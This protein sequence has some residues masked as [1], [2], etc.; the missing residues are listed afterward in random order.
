MHDPRRAERHWLVMA[1]A[2]LWVVSVGG[3]VDAQ[4]PAST[5]DALPETHIA[6]TANQGRQKPRKMSCFARGIM[7]ITV[8][9]V[10]GCSLSPGQFVPFMWPT[11]PVEVA[12]GANDLTGREKTYPKGQ[13][14]PVPLIQYGSNLSNEE[15]ESKT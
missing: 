1:V 12:V 5:L 7:R 15:K 8:A 4:Q 14:V 10:Q 6:R 11:S 13:S 3:E 9:Q 2:T